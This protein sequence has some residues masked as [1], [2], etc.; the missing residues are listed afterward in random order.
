MSGAKRVEG[1]WVAGVVLAAVAV[2]GLGSAGCA[3]HTQGD[4]REIAYDFSDRDFYDRAYAPSPKYL[5]TEDVYRAPLAR[6]AAVAVP[7]ATPRA[8]VEA[9]TVEPLRPTPAA[10]RPAARGDA[11]EEEAAPKLRLTKAHL[12]SLTA[13]SVAAE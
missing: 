1:S 6:T 8:E 12:G 2:A 3:I 13:K 7:A 4:I 11:G 10:R 9:A 5:E